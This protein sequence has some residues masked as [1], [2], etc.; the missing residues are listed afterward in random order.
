MRF[1]RRY[2]DVNFCK[3]YRPPADSAQEHLDTIVPRGVVPD[4]RAVR[5]KEDHHQPLSSQ[6][7]RPSPSVTRRARKTC[8]T[9]KKHVVSWEHV[10][11][12]YTL[13]V[14]SNI[15]PV[16]RLQVQL[17]RVPRYEDSIKVALLAFRAFVSPPK[18]KKDTPRPKNRRGRIATGHLSRLKPGD[19]LISVALRPGASAGRQP[20]AG[21]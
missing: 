6:K 13:S 1:R 15:P 10:V 17:S 3:L 21:E 12:L 18:G 19:A 16:L 11:R 20:G 7:E 5:A 14:L 2:E 4:I 9:E 8:R